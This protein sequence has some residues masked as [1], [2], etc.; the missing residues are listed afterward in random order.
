[1]FEKFSNKISRKSVHWKP[2]YS[3]RV[4]ERADTHDEADSRF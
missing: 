4:D 2:S 1:M 3:M